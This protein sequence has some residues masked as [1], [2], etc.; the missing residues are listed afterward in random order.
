MPSL[1]VGSAISYGWKKFTENVGG[2]IVLML[3]VFIAMM[4]MGAVNFFLTSP[5][6]TFSA[7]VWNLLVTLVVYTVIF[8]VQAGIWRAGLGVTRGVAP[9]INQLGETTNLA[10]Y[11]FTVIIVYVVPNLVSALFGWIS[12]FLSL[13]LLIPIIAW[14]ILTAFS[15]LLALD[16]GLSPVDAI[17]RSFE[18][19]K[20]NAGSVILILIVA[21]LVYL[22]GL[23]LCGLGVFVSAP[24]S[25]VAITYAYRALSNE[26]VVP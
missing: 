3:V 10:Q 21:G 22:A 26:P 18:M 13:L 15:P 2:F 9:S 8:M 16:K 25:L 7:L 4:V 23:C 14:S 11:A 20:E 17:T 1:D 24:V 5:R 12:P 19:V 6:N